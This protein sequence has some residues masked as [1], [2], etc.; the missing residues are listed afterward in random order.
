MSVKKLIVALAAVFVAALVVAPAAVAQD[1]L[2]VNPAGTKLLFENA[3]VR[4]Y[5]FRVKPGEKIAMH[6]HPDHSVYFLSGGKVRFTLPDGKTEERET[7]SGE[8]IFSNALS[9]AAEN[10]GA[11]EVRG[12]ATEMK[13][14]AMAKEQPKKE[15][16]KY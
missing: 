5:E 9:H 8:A 10:I 3:E 12:V 13:G 11:T 2:K 6:S 16:M 15:K 4:I 14:S 1:P 7:K